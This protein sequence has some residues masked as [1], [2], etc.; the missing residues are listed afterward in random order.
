MI[1]RIWGPKQILPKEGERG[2]HAPLNLKS[3]LIKY[4]SAAWFFVETN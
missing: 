2:R 1:F 3:L 4:H